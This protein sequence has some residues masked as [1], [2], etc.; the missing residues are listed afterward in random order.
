MR[1]DDAAVAHV[2]KLARLHLTEAEL[3]AMRGELAQI[4]DHVAMLGA[5]DTA[6][7]APL[8]QPHADAMPQRPDE[9]ASSLAQADV[10]ALAP[11]AN[12]GHFVVPRVV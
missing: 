6:G 3:A 7:V 1:V 12:Q 11:A 10:L 2:A 4:L 9:V 8:W 5:I